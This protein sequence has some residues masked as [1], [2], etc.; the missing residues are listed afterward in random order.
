MPVTQAIIPVAGLGTRFLPWT[1]A[2]PKE[3]LPL[4]TKPI[5]ALIVDECLDAGIRD[6]CFVLAHGK[7]SIVQ[8]FDRDEKLEQDLSSRGKLSLLDDVR[9]YDDVRFQV[10]YQEQQLGD[11]HAI[12]QAESWVQSDMV[13]VLFGDDLF[14]GASSGLQQLLRAYEATADAGQRAVIAAETIPR[15]ATKRYGILDVLPEA[16]SL[17]QLKRVRGLVEKPE[18]AAAPSTLGIVGRYLIPRTLFQTLRQ[19]RSGTK[20]GEIRLIDA[21][22]AAV[23]SLSIFGYECEGE[24]IDTGTPEGY[25]AALQRFHLLK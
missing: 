22:I 24:R 9:R 23:G 3:L 8:Y 19:V 5:I 25:Y 13:A 15:E 2:V 16:L 18:P 1:K 7:E 17:P 6:I 4:G 14:V 20:D 10:V 21:L 12:L 11:G